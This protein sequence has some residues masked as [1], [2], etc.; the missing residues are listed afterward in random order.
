MCLLSFTDIAAVLTSKVDQAT[1]SSA[2][3]KKVAS[4]DNTTGNANRFSGSLGMLYNY[5][6]F[7]FNSTKGNNFNRFAGHTNLYLGGV[8]NVKLPY[9][10]FAGLFY[11]HVDSDIRSNVLLSPTPQTTTHL[12]GHNNS[13]FAHVFKEIKT[14]FLINAFGGYGHDDLHYDIY[15]T[16]FNNLPAQIANA[17]T[18]SNNWFIGGNGLYVNSWHDFT[19]AGTIGVLYV[20]TDVDSY[21]Y[22]FKPVLQ[23]GLVAAITNKSTFTTEGIE[24]GYKLNTALQPFING[25]LLQVV[26]FSNS[27]PVVSGTVE[28]A[29][30]VFNLNQDGYNLGGGINITYK[31]VT[32]RLLQEYYKR[33]HVYHSNQSTVSLKISIT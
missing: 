4:K 16:P 29:L 7:K 6:D 21:S 1:P 18:S 15:V 32:L 11:Y 13:L 24:L 31:Q 25:G 27:R 19:Y 3:A 26:Q 8:D 14:N 20:N 33:G 17:N 5:R 9:D 22:L 30:P 28:G 23:P 2:T 12:D 10:F